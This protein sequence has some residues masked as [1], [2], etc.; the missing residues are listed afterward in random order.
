MSWLSSWVSRDQF[1][2]DE[3]HS[4][5]RTTNM[6]QSG[7]TG[8]WDVLDGEHNVLEALSPAPKPD[9]K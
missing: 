3:Q 9:E 5:Q 6:V 8:V 4:T 7:L 1:L 2:L